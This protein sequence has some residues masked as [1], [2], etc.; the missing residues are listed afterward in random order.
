[1]QSAPLIQTKLPGPKAKKI[2]ARD[3]RLLSPS[4][5][6]PYPLVIDKGEGVVV[7]DVDGNRFLDF[8]SGIAVCSTGHSN[9]VVLEAIQKQTSRFLHMCG[10]DFYYDSQVQLA[11]RLTRLAPGKKRK[12]VY[13]TNSGAEAVEGAIKL[14]RYRT[15]RQKILGFFGGFHGRTLGALSLTNSKAVQRSFFGPL[16]PE[17]HHAPYGDLEYIEKVLFKKVFSPKELAAVVVEPVQGEGGYFVPPKN[18]LSG[19][20][21]LADRHGFLLVADEIQTGIG[22]TGK[23][24]AVEHWGVVPDV[25]CLAKGIASG[26]PLGAVIATEEAM[27]WVPGSQGSTFGGNPVSCVAAI[28]TV[29]LVQ[30]QYMKNAQKVGSY[31]KPKLESLRRRKSS[32][33]DVRGMGL[34]LAIEIGS[35]KTKKLDHGKRNQIVANAFKKGLLLLGCGESSIRLTPPLSVTKEEADKAVSILNQVL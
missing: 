1:M 30:K 15:R 20:R 29:D 34:M 19:L 22:R 12:R 2:I 35:K 17:F 28:A 5:T 26:M 25:I 9:P 32:V 18:F 3:Q 27:N 4:L 8:T 6:R 10:A 14:A 24:F 7:Q 23:M 31:L 16:V 33:V 11:E 13:F 21:R